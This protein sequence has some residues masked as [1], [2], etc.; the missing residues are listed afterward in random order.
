MPKN[1]ALKRVKLFTMSMGTVIM[2]MMVVQL[3]ALPAGTPDMSTEEDAT[4]GRFEEALAI[5]DAPSCHTCKANT[6]HEQEERL[7]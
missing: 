5:C 3:L 4:D 2:M 6:A 1:L 7:E